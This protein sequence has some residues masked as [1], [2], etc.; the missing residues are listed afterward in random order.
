MTLAGSPKFVGGGD[1]LGLME[2]AGNAEGWRLEAGGGERERVRILCRNRACVQDPN[3]RS[4]KAQQ[5]RKEKRT[6]KK[7][8]KVRIGS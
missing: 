2:A 1:G 6:K 3:G 4:S 7:K 5:Q 8:F